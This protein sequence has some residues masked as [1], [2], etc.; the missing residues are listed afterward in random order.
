MPDK[1]EPKKKRH[2]V[3]NIIIIAA[4][5]VLVYSLYN[6]IYIVGSNTESANIYSG[7]RSYTSVLNT[8]TGAAP[9]AEGGLTASGGLDLVV[10]FD[11]LRTM[12]EETAAW[13]VVPGTEVDYPVVHTDNNDYYLNHAA[14]GTE[15]R[16]GAIFIDALNAPDFSDQNTIVYGHNMQSGAMFASLHAFED[17]AF[18]NEHTDIYVYTPDGNKRT[19]RI[20]SAFQTNAIGDTYTI[21]F[22]D[23]ASFDQYVADARAKSTAPTDVEV[24]STD[25]VITLSTCIR[26]L[27]TKRYVV[28]GVLVANEPVL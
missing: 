10:D 18:F 21:T 14:D 22:A 1:T 2:V 16:A 20:F 7:L 12:N 26:G 25:K 28:H 5:A 11:A 3:T 9:S 13:I 4:I 23:E 27:S 17:T 24:K 8:E 6:I 15:N 19:Y